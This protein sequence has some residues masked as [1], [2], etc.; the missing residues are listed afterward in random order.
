LVS[1]RGARCTYGETSSSIDRVE[2]APIRD[3]EGAFHRALG[4]TSGRRRSDGGA[5]ASTSRARRNAGGSAAAGTAALAGRRLA[6][7]VR[8]RGPPVS[9]VRLP[10][11]YV[12]SVGW[13]RWGQL[14]AG[15]WAI[16]SVKGRESEYRARQAPAHLPR[17]WSHR[18][19]I[20]QF[21]APLARTTR[22]LVRPAPR[23]P[24]AL[25]RQT[26]PAAAANVTRPARPRGD[27]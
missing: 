13:P 14:P 2:S 8:R 19:L 10:S 23:P 3:R 24:S 4:S 11:A 18:A 7:S 21:A 15:A 26:I 12:T 20:Q 16:C 17:A 6:R 5:R 22:R 1:T 27:R 9:L 25:A